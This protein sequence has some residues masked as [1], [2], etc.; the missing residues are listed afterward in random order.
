MGITLAIE[1][2]SFVNF[3]L[4]YPLFAV[5]VLSLL[6]DLSIQSDDYKRKNECD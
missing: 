2:V 3:F 6:Q 4:Q 1:I 5:Y